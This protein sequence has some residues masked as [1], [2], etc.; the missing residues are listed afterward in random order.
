[1][2]FQK[3]CAQLPLVQVVNFFK[4]NK[5]MDFKNIE[6]FLVLY[7]AITFICSS[8]VP[9][10]GLIIGAMYLNDCPIQKNVPVWLIGKE[11]F[12]IRD[13]QNYH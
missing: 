1:M 5:N 3:K 2:T 10:A 6:H 9:L 8:A 12:K 11:T 13:F 7:F 4:K